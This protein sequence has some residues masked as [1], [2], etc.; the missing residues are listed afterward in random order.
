MSLTV[1]WEMV[2]VIQSVQGKDG[3]HAS[4]QFFES[5]IKVR[6]SVERE[7]A[8]RRVAQ[9]EEVQRRHAEAFSRGLIEI[10]YLASM[11]I[12]HEIMRIL[13]KKI[14]ET[15]LTLEELFPTHAIYFGFCSLSGRRLLEEMSAFVTDMRRNAAFKLDNGEYFTEEEFWRVAQAEILFE[16]HI[17]ALP[18]R[19]IET[20]L[21]AI[22]HQQSSRLWYNIGAGS[23]YQSDRWIEVFTREQRTCT[24]FVT[25]VPKSDLQSVKF[26]PDLPLFAL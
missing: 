21:Q 9:V 10:T 25:Y 6:Q 18:A 4:D 5:A 19:L 16:S 23:Y 7:L 17:N 24:V 1:A 15:G 11:N 2:G 14:G 13:T 3:P 20:E 12:D 8:R 22:F 26:H